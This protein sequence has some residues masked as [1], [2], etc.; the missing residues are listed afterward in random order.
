MSAALFKLGKYRNWYISIVE[1]APRCKPKHGYYEMHHIV[2]KSMLGGNEKANLAY[3]TAREHFL[4]HWLLT[5][6]VGT[7]EHQIKVDFAFSKMR[8]S[9]GDQRTV[10]SV[11]YAAASKANAR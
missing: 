1:R 9:S 11:Q 6:M 7:K 3:L 2:P 8:W 4:V 10:T 5:K